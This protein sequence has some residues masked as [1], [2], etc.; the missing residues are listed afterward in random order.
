MP[1]ITNF[2][3]SLTQEKYKLVHMGTI[4]YSKYQDLAAGFSNPS[5][6][7]KEIQGFEAVRQEEARHTQIFRWRFESLQGQGQ[8][9]AGE[10][11][12]HLLSQREKY[13]ECMYE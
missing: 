6:G 11:Q 8:E 1:L 12:M 7:K 2:M 3:E 5:K 4:K 9:E 13:K 10:Y